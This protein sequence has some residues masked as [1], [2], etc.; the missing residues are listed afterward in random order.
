MMRR[1]GCLAL[2]LLVLTWLTGCALQPPAGIIP[3]GDFEIARYLGQWYEIARLDHSFERGLS[4]V[5]ATYRPREDGGIEV[6]NRGYDRA[7]GQWRESQGRA[8]FLGDPRT[9]SLKVSFFRPFYG[10]YHVILLDKV[11][12]TYAMVSG[13]D[14]SYLW[15]LARTRTLDKALLDKLVNQAGTLGYP[16]DQLIYVEQARPDA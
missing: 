11:N 3:V 4:N 8:Y 15:I 1:G 7:A 9:G 6:I 14:K 12:Y 16:V 13:P 10:G 2:L 5:S